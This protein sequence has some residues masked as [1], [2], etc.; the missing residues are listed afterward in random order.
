MKSN[1]P[2]RT[3]SIAVSS[4]PNPL[5]RITCVDGETSRKVFNSAIP[6]RRSF[7]LMSLMIRS[8]LPDRTAS[9]AASESSAELT[10][11]PSSSKISRRKLQVSR[12]SSITRMFL[13]NALILF[14]HA[15]YWF[16]D[17]KPD[18]ELR[19]LPGVALDFYR[20][21]VLP[22]DLTHDRQP[23]AA[24]PSAQLCGE[25]RVENAWL[26]FLFDAF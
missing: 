10:L 1:A 23:Q 19:A 6:F 3:D 13:D 24:A 11:K 22:D 17:W 15:A 7:R 20:A 21:A 8:N 12:S 14:S 9:S 16:H 5:I 18:F 2:S 26:D 4:V 25:E